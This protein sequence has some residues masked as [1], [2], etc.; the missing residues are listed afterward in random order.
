MLE[1]IRILLE[2]P[3]ERVTVRSHDGLKLVG[4][5][6]EGQPGAPLILFST[7]TDPRRS[8]TAAAAFSCAGNRGGTS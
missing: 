5:F 2:T 3:Y 7:A 1:N 4:K 8:G 6:Y